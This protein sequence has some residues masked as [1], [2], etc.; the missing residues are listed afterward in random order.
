MSHRGNDEIKERLWE[1]VESMTQPAALW[2]QRETDT[3]AEAS[4]C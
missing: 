4:R 1:K 2:P 3:A